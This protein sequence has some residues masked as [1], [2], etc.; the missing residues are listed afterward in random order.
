MMPKNVLQVSW[1]IFTTNH[2]NGSKQIFKY[3]LPI[4]ETDKEEIYEKNNIIN[5]QSSSTFVGVTHQSTLIIPEVYLQN[6]VNFGS[7]IDAIN[8]NMGTKTE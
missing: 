2:Q 5:D 6:S 8:T 1:S 4:A 7:C 3:H